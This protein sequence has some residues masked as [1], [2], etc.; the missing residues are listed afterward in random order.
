MNEVVRELRDAWEQ[1]N[2]ELMLPRWSPPE[3]AAPSAAK[4]SP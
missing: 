1:W 3:A 2:A 4:N